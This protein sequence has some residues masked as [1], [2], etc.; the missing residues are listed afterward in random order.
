MM[1]GVSQKHTIVPWSLQTL[2]A[3]VLL[4]NLNIK[5]Q[6]MKNIPMKVLNSTHN[7]SAIVRWD[8]LLPTNGVSPHLMQ[9][10]SVSTALSSL[11]LLP[12]GGIQRLHAFLH[13][14]YSGK[15]HKGQF[16]TSQIDWLWS[17]PLVVQAPCIIYFRVSCGL[18]QYIL[19]FFLPCILSHCRQNVN[20]SPLQDAITRG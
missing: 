7:G 14:W 18:C 13:Q 15:G 6:L 2:L 12:T 3:V 8:Q 1:V 5:F 16:V 11:W 20:W 19:V 10:H 17:I 4:H 9:Q